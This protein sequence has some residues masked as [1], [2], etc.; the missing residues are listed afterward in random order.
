MKQA[1]ILHGTDASPK[2]NWFM[3]LKLQLEQIGYKVWL[4]QLPNCDRPN[5]KTY[6]NFLLTNPDFKLNNN[7]I[8]IGH[9]SSAVEILHLLQSLSD[10]TKIK[11]AFLV[12]AFVND[13][14]WDVLRGLFTEQLDFAKIKTMADKLVIVHSDNDPYVPLDHA[15]FLAVNLDG[16]LVVVKGQG[17]FN[18]E[19]SKDY[20]TFPLLLGLIKAK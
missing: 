3:W 12:S 4:P 14:G 9:S 10:D 6:N 16:K 17:H 11:S 2:S 19:Q 5:S 1:L 7:T 20:E 8:I 13:L 15:R 18:I